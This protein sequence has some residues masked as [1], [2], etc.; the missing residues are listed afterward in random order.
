MKL[1]L[2]MKCS[3]RVLDKLKRE[4]L[5]DKKQMKGMSWEHLLLNKNQR[6]LE[7]SKVEEN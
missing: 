3:H 1:K 6:Q 2:I 7:S 4:N 5:I